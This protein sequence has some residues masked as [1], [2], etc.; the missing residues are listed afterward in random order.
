MLGIVPMEGTKDEKDEAEDETGLD[1]MLTMDADL[2]TKLAL[3]R[4]L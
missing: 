3:A 4:L 2:L 1:T